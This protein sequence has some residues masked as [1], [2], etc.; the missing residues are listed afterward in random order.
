M[1]LSLPTYMLLKIFHTSKIFF[2]PYEGNFCPTL[3][4]L[5]L[6]T[7]LHPCIL[8]YT[9][10]HCYDKYFWQYAPIKL[11]LPQDKSHV[12]ACLARCTISNWRSFVCPRAFCAK[13]ITVSVLSPLNLQSCGKL[14]KHGS[15]QLLI[16]L[17]III[18]IKNGKQQH[19]FSTL[20]CATVTKNR[21]CAPYV[22]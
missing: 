18:I 1:C 7:A 11:S 6:C 20:F 16:I 13:I 19:N 22:N 4:S 8:Q 10:V 21:Y 15:K 17:V 9:P 2:S 12:L 14:N 5:P 3:C